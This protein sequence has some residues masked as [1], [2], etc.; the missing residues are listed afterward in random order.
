MNKLEKTLL[1]G[2]MG[3]NFMTVFSYI[4]SMLA[5]E[6]FSEPG[7]LSTMIHRLLPAFPKKANHT[8][9]WAS[10]YVMGILFAAVYVELW[11]T[12]KIK[13]TIKNGIIMGTLSGALAVLI[14]KTTFKLHPLPPWINYRRYYI[15]LVSAHVVYAVFATLT[16]R[17][18]KMQEE[19]NEQIEQAA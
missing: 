8:A 13:H 12:G 6:D 3:T 17:I 2:I 1:S 16:Y 10:H 7:H 15:Q 14:W 19:K 4:V 5:K 9:G 11:E 18:I